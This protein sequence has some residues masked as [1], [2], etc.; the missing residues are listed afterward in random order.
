[1]PN[2]QGQRYRPQQNEFCSVTRCVQALLL[3]KPVD[4]P[5]RAEVSHRRMFPVDPAAKLRAHRRFSPDTAAE[6]ST[7]AKAHVRSP[8]VFLD[9]RIV[10]VCE[11]FYHRKIKQYIWCV[12]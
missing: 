7:A 11:R 3:D 8:Q 5:G 2:K 1:M 6:R 4:C 10:Q 12:S 9:A